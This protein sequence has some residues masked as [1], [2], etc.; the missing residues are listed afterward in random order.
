MGARGPIWVELRCECAEALIVSNSVWSDVDGLQ[1]H[2]LETADI[3][4]PT[5]MGVMVPMNL[6][7]DDLIMMSESAT[8]LQK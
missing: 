4:A 1:K 6:Y 2:L 3:D 7:A 5:L 8:R